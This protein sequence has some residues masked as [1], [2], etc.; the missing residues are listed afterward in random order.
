MKHSIMARV[1]R[2]ILT[3]LFLL[4]ATSSVRSQALIRGIATDLLDPRSLFAN[5]ALASFQRPMLSAGVKVYY[6][7]LLANQSTPFK[8]GFFS[9]A[10]P[11]V[12]GEFGVGITGQYFQSPMLNRA[13]LGLQLSRRL[14]RVLSLGVSA[15]AYALSYDAA[16]FDLV[17]EDDPVF[18]GGTQKLTLTTSAGLLFIP[19][20]N[21]SLALGGRHLNQPDL[22]LL[23]DG[24]RQPILPF[25]AVSFSVGPLRA[26]VAAEKFPDRLETRA[27]V[28][29]FETGGNFFR[30]GGGLNGVAAAAQM[31]LAG[32][33][34]I[35]YSYELP[36]NQMRGATSGSHLITLIFD[37][38]RL[39][40]LPDR[41]L[42]PAQ[43]FHV[44]PP[45]RLPPPT[46]RILVWVT[47]PEV[48]VYEKRIIRRIDPEIERESLLKLTSY[49]IG[50]LDSTFVQSVPPFE[51]EPVEVVTA[52]QPMGRLLSSSYRQTLRRIRELFTE[53][54]E[55]RVELLT[56][57]G[58]V[59]R[60]AQLKAELASGEEE[61]D[62]RLIV[63][64]A[65][66]VDPADS[67]RFFSRVLPT[68]LLPE[69]RL[70]FAKPEETTI[71]FLPVY[72]QGGISSWR[73]EIRNKEGQVVRLF[74]GGSVL[75][76]R[77][78]W[79][80]RTDSGEVIGPGTYR[81]LL[82]WTD[83]RGERRQSEEMRFYVRKFLRTIHVEIT[84]DP[85][86]LD[87]EVKDIN[88]YLNK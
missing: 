52:P 70:V 42:P 62:E 47:D 8:Q 64:R 55:L 82:T 65:R 11:H 27:F 87:P 67:L 71:E 28:E 20:E 44:D 80:W 56:R 46:P 86:R 34:A 49:D 3:A 2:L 83:E 51:P 84:K 58:A 37:F 36:V 59:Y 4:V 48:E 1:S 40:S 73:L 22:S 33:L 68:S 35:N 45:G 23:G 77:L 88:I 85:T 30:L 32:P 16:S 60:A 78:R 19:V 9:I 61:D 54:P 6:L 10:G 13:V 79:D 24:V 29:A 41:V 7:G 50:V 57:D 17:D 14:F 43:I 15:S 72:L 53:R 31:R 81:C 74:S 38:D 76:Q 5:P 12:F 25:A 39:S 26:T 66:F 18:R 69:E 63:A 21:F 75:P